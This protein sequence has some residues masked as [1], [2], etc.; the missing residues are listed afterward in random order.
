[1]SENN[2]VRFLDAF[3]ERQDLR[4]QGFEFPKENEQGKGRPGYHPGVLLGLYLYGYLHGVRSSRRLEE[5][6]G[7]NLEVMWLLRGLKPDFKTIA[8]FR[9]DNP[10]AFKKVNREF[11]K[12]CQQLN[13]FGKELFAVDGTKIKGQNARDQNWSQS[14]LEKQLKEATEKMTKYLAEMNRVDQEEEAVSVPVE[15]LKE[16]MEYWKKQQEQAQERLKTL[17]QTKESQLSA[18]DPESRGMKGNYGHMVG[19]NVQGAVDAKHGLIAVL[20]PTNA[21]ADQG[22]LVP[23]AQAIKKEME[24]EQAEIIADGGYFKNQD[25]KSCQEMKMEVYVPGASEPEGFYGKKNFQYD[26]QNNTYHCPAGQVLKFRR[27]AKDKGTIRFNYENPSACAQCQLRSRCTSKQARTVSRWEF[28][29]SIQR[30]QQKIAQAPEKLARRKGL[31]EHCWGTIK[32]LLSGGFLVKG[33]KKVGAETNLVQIAYNLKR[34]L[35]VVGLQE[36]MTACKNAVIQPK[37]A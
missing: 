11:L 6:C 31:I 3:V 20:E 16:K 32:H 8:D 5:E 9:K 10:E 35:A 23:M 19:Y 22:Q 36:L 1:V 29:E 13:L 26:D 33:L 25:I 14:K 24:V 28:E 7:R 34:A 37:L 21:P 17:E 30:M 2:P 15:K 4:T 12:M 18:T 27:R